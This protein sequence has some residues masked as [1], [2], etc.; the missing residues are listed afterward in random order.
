M[1]VDLYTASVGV[2]RRGLEALA[3]ILEVGAEHAEASGRSE[4]DLLNA[5]LA[6][7]MFPLYRQAQIACDFARQVPARLKGEPRPE[8]LEGEP[9]LAEL[10]QQI[11]AVRA[12]LDAVTP[13]MLAGRDGEPVTFN[14]GQ[15]VTL[16]AG[17][18]LLGFALH[19]FYFHLTSAYAIAR[20]FG[21]PLGKRDFFAGGF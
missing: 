4:A 7:D 19:N 15:D 8:A 2:L 18:Y 9:T 10:R 20:H 14:I 17:Q 13:E 3:R 1:Q 21:A 11:A 5:R 16:P 12:E 6:P